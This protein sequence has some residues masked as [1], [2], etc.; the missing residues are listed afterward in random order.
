MRNGLFWGFMTAVA[1]FIIMCGFLSIFGYEL[2]LFAGGAVLAGLMI[3]CTFIICEKYE[4]WAGV[5]RKSR[6]DRMGGDQ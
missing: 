2:S 1:F 5:Q 3:A 6:E 4:K